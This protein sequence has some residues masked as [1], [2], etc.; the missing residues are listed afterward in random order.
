MKR[1]IV[2]LVALF[3]VIFAL[4]A[5]SVSTASAFGNPF[6]T[7]ADRKLVLNKLPEK[8]QNRAD[9]KKE[10][11]IS[12]IGSVDMVYRDMVTDNLGNEARFYTGCVV[13]TG[14]SEKTL[15]KEQYMYYFKVVIVQPAVWNPDKQTWVKGEPEVDQ[16]KPGG[17]LWIEDKDFKGADSRTRNFN[18]NEIKE[19]VKKWKF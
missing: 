4:V 6:F 17:F 1:S 18:T 12:K 15:N 7:D 2:M 10:W 14:S 16:F 19:V 8:A 13:I 5:G 9:P 3:A 11:I